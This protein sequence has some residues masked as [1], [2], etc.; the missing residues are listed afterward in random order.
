[1]SAGLPTVYAIDD[2]ETNLR[3][4]KAYLQGEP[5]SVVTFSDGEEALRTVDEEPP[6]LILLDLMMPVIDGFAMLEAL[7]AKAPQVPVVIVTATDERDARLRA[8][9]A[10]ARD[11][12]T[13]P[14]DRS[15]LLIR[16]RNLVA[17]KQST[18]A[19]EKAVSELRLANRD[20]QSFAATLAHDLQQ[21]ITTINA[22][23]QV[24]QSQGDKLPAQ[25][26]DHLKRIAGACASARG[27]IHA[28]LEFARL[29]QA[30]VKREVVDLNEVIAEARQTVTA[31]A[32]ARA[33][34]WKIGPMPV[35]Q[36][37]AA[38]LLLACVN[39][40]SNAVKYTRKQDQP[41]ISVSASWHP[42]NGHSIEFRDNGVGFDMAH[43][44]KLFRP[45][46]RLHSV[47][48]FEGTG[49]GL[50]NVQRIV[51]KHGGTIKAQARPG[52]G[53]VFTLVLR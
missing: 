45:F 14:V 8:L 22:F 5:Y 32:E 53:A 1:M 30:R 25:S 39:L 27:M 50:A 36:G 29:G 31:G 40:L 43:A 51:E 6:D 16:V 42:H 26:A 24:I 23:T 12:I 37:D 47:N 44:A 48:E 2:K 18:D 3:L 35:V 33:I 41:R 11:F 21:P 13:K 7:A 34:D 46:E 4:L 49:M 38:L 17:L 10:G 28:L 15:E 9:A 52:E 19:L 20:L